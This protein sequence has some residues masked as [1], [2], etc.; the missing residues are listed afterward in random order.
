MDGMGLCF[1]PE[2]YIRHMHFEEKPAC[3]SVGDGGIFST[4]TIA[5]R[6]GAY[7]L[8]YAQDFIRIARER[9]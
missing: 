6:K 8:S 4:L 9:L 5:S 1:V 7:L 3:F 2:T